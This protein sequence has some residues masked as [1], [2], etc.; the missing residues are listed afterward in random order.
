M[1]KT[2]GGRPQR[3]ECCSEEGAASSLE[4]MTD[5]LTYLSFGIHYKKSLLYFHSGFKGDRTFYRF[6][7]EGCTL[8]IHNT[9]QG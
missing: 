9:F 5:T 7:M 3:P 8:I 4:L 6:S 2:S 1:S